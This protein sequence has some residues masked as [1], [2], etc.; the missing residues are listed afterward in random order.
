MKLG[1]KQEEYKAYISIITIIALILDLFLIGKDLI[2]YFSTGSFMHDGVYF[3]Y[4]IFMLFIL[5]FI[6]FKFVKS[7]FIEK[8]SIT[9]YE[10]GVDINGH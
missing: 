6:V 8:E 9:I 3:K 5:M 2:E 1:R 4:Y 7:R 10:H